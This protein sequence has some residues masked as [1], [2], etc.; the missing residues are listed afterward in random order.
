[1]SL[2]NF[3]S[4]AAQT[5]LAGGVTSTATT[6]VVS[7]TTGFPAAPYILAIEP[8]AANQELVLVTAVAGT[9][10][11]VTRGYDSTTGVDHSAGAVVQHSHGA[12]D[13]REANAHVNATAN[14]HG[15][16]TPVGTTETQTLTNKTLSADSNTI[17]GIAA[18]SF[19]MSDALGNLDGAAAQKAIPSGAVVGTSDTQTLTNKTVNL[20]NNTLTGT[21][22]QFNTAISDADMATLAGTETLTGKTVNL[23]SNTL[24][25]TT[26]QFN[27]ALSDNDFATLAGVETLTNKTLTSP[28]ITDPVITGIGGV[29]TVVK[30]TPETVTSST[31]YQDDDHLQFAASASATYIIEIVLYWEASATA[32]GLNGRLTNTGGTLTMYRSSAITDDASL[33][34]PFATVAANGTTTTT[35]ALVSS[36]QG[37]GIGAMPLTSR[38]SVVIT[39]GTAGTVKLQWAQANSNATNTRVFAGSYLR[40][41]RVS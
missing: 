10:L 6:L 12:I 32:G 5:T 38:L 20:A 19:V 4:T 13:F 30:P 16:V 1:M 35:T 29:Q 26:A 34:P 18:S 3:S 40:A 9:S 41:T 23:A 11:T 21:A 28:A 2:R 25:G 24:S 15:V 22:A 17:S 27:T 14:V 36:W 31:T 39:T 8:G 7:A 37:Y 33:T